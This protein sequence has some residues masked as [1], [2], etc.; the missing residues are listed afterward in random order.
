M[1]ILFAKSMSDWLKLRLVH[2]LAVSL[3]VMITSFSPGALIA[4]DTLQATERPSHGPALLIEHSCGQVTAAELAAFK[5]HLTFQTAPPRG[6]R[7]VY[8]YGNPGKL[9]EACGLMLE[10]TDDTLILNKMLE[11]CDALLASRN[12]L[13]T[14]SRGGQRVAWT[15]N[16]APVWPSNGT[17][18]QLAGAG[19]EQGSICAHLLMA[20][21]YILQH[22][23]IWENV[24]PSPVAGLNPF[25]QTYKQRAVTYIQAADKVMEDWILP[26]FVRKDGLFYFPGAPNTY[27][28][29]Q[30]APWNQ[31]FML[32]NGLIRL[33]A[34]HYLLGD[35]ADK[36]KRYD[37]LVSLNI[38]WF[39][40]NVT[41]YKD[42]RGHTF[43]KFDYALGSRK[44]D[45]NH[46]AYDVEGMFLAYLGEKYGVTAG[47]M[48]A[49]ANTFFTV[50]LDTTSAHYRESGR[51]AGYVDGTI[52]TG[53]AGGDKYIRDE[54]LY[55]LLFKKELLPYLTQIER[56]SGKIATSPQIVARLLWVREFLASRP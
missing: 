2:L 8:V 11:L 20:S 55:L 22:P 54:Y 18:K 14:A 40:Q 28:P 56:Q 3:I 6:D 45:T 12:D 24:V 33:S 7:N 46:F 53:H 15:G 9:I 29:G 38:K 41:V 44:E 23:S 52:G 50:V 5:A 26:H 37:R 34:C 21:V 30:P 1:Q 35:A 43:W 10:I 31:L 48:Q 27:K 19:I 13:A 4:Q 16:V 51:F 47:D 25:G 42:S 17:D 36:V 32:T 39:K 49:M